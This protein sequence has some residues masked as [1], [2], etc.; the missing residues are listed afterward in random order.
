MKHIIVGGDG[1]VGRHLAH[2]LIAQG[3]EVV[4]GG[5]S[6]SDL[7]IYEKGR[8]IR[9]DVTEPE[10]LAKL[11]I[12]ADDVVY[13]LAARMLVPI[14]P[15]AQRHE[16]F[17]SV[18][19]RGTENLLALMEARDCGKFVYFTT[20]MVYGHTQTVPKYEDHPRVPLGPYG[21]SKYQSELL[22]E[23]Y[24][25]KGMKISIFRPRL[26]IGPGRLGI[27]QKLFRLIEL[28]LPVP[29]IG[30]GS[31]PY[32]FISVFDCASAAARAAEKGVPNSAYNLGS[33]DPPSVRDLLKGLID[34]AGSRSLLIPTP[35]GLVKGTL[36]LLDR[37]GTPLMDPEQY[38]IADER[39]IV[40]VSKADRELDWRPQHRDEDMLR[41][42]YVEYRNQRSGSPAS[43]AHQGVEAPRP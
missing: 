13:N 1:F 18:N 14:L 33:V 11:P 7:E 22:C 5:L 21:D 26:I 23:A 3:E 34:A 4:I 9:A 10:Q 6:Q 8:F 24:R 36:D 42:A 40:D 37:I 12:E 31:N 29:L 30:D 28:N 38:L 41:A 15:R 32:Q 35:A 17:F 43:D 2:D 20:D 39:C 19:T 25:E 27:L 16:Y